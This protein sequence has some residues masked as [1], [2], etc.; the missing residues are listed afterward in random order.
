MVPFPPSP[1]SQCGRVTKFWPKACEEGC[2]V[3][4]SREGASLGCSPRVRSAPSSVSSLSSHG[5]AQGCCQLR[6]CT[7]DPSHRQDGVPQKLQPGTRW[8]VFV[9]R[10][11][12]L[13]SLNHSHCVLL[14]FVAESNGNGYFQIRVSFFKC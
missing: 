4:A 8:N 6:P 12:F 10:D 3:R 5:L 9:T 1:A 11:K 13:S 2:P 14:S 7:M